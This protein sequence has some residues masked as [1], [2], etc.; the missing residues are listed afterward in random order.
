MI[1]LN[2]DS[3]GNMTKEYLESV[4]K[5]HELIEGLCECPDKDGFNRAF[6]F[7]VR[8]V[9]YKI[10]WWCNTS[11][12]HIGEAFLPFGWLE[13]SGTWP[14]GFKNNIQFADRVKEGQ[15]DCPNTVAVIPLEEYKEEK[16]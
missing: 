15:F 4:L 3:V 11:Y 8:G 10:I 14:N 12:L 2:K 6:E 7:T 5:S 9:K 13:I 16:G 1:K